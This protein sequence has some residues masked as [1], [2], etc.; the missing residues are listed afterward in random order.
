MGVG[1]GILKQEYKFMLHKKGISLKKKIR[2]KENPN[3]E[4][5]RLPC[6]GMVF[7]MG[8]LAQQDQHHLRTC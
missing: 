4:S 8:S 5:V 6:I 1:G 2:L 3:A 7:R